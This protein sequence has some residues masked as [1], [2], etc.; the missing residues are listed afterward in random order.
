MAKIFPTLE[1]IKR[2]KVQPMDGEFFD[3]LFEWKSIGWYRNIFSAIFK[4]TTVFANR[5]S[6][7][8]VRSEHW[9]STNKPVVMNENMNDPITLQY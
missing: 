7:K 3:R 2:L 1:N 9:T 5:R 4:C 8:T 6:L